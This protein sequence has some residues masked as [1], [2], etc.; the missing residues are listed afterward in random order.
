M[1]LRRTLEDKFLIHLAL[2]LS[3]AG[4][5]EWVD[6]VDVAV[7]VSAA[8]ADVKVRALELNGVWCE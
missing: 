7:I 8:V 6:V 5:T 3:G 2:V 4:E 1:S